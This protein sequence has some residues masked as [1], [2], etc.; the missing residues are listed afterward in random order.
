VHGTY[1]KSKQWHMH[2]LS[3]SLSLLKAQLSI[4]ER[5]IHGAKKISPSIATHNVQH[6]AQTFSFLFSASTPAHAVG[7]LSLL[8][9]SQKSTSLVF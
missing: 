1:C 2:S 9:M 3:L 5:T 7:G 4:G 8:H 6:S